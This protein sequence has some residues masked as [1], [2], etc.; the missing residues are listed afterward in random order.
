M[1]G[2]SAISHSPKLLSQFKMIDYCFPKPLW[3]FGY[4]VY[5][6][7]VRDLLPGLFRNIPGLFEAGWY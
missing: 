6:P 4:S 7:D 5:I 1:P 2:N 3:L